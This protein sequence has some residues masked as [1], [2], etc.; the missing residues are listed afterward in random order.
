MEVI[1]FFVL[2]YNRPDDTLEALQNILFH[3]DRPEHVFV[4]IIVINNNSSVDYSVFDRFVEQNQS[5][6]V[7]RILYEVNDDN[8]GVAG[9][10]NQAMEMATG[11]ILIS[12]DDDAEFVERDV[13]QRIVDL[14]K[15]YEDQ[16]VQILT[17]KVNEVADGSI[18]I[19]SK[20]P[21]RFAKKELFTTYFAGGAHAIK[22]SVLSEVG[23]Y[24]VGEKY[25]AEEY[26]LSYKILEHGAKIVHTNEIS[27]LHKK[28]AQ[29][30]FDR[31]RQNGNLLKNKSLVAYKF[32]PIKYFY[33]HLFFWSFYFLKYSG[34]NVT[35]LIHY[36]KI[37]WRERKKIRRKT[38]SADTL[39]YIL[40]VGGRLTY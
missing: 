7:H 11:S 29:G 2:T 6:D 16:N 22:K 23:M 38:I 19:A 13:I 17:F 21:D 1:S 10:R 34:G 25:G 5:S 20:S 36:L 27:I 24:D 32:L 4:E 28:A 35:A 31:A 12:L 14:F 26:D 33:S 15:K 18:T 37:T 39:K 3:L 9:G 8:L 30:R 40:D